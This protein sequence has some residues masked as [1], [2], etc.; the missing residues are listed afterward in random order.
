MT[1]IPG[2]NMRKNTIRETETIRQFVDTWNLNDRLCRATDEEIG[3]VERTLGITLPSVYTYLM[4]EFG[5]I[6]TPYILDAVVEQRIAFPDVQD[7]DLPLIALES[8]RACIRAGMPEG[9]FGFAW[10][11]MGNRFCFRCDECTAGRED[12]PVWYFDHDV[13]EM[14]EISVS[15]TEWLAFY[16][17]LGVPRGRR[18]GGYAHVAP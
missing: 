13:L 15:F 5:D 8:T 16:A 2:E 11:C 12:S 17:R 4:R 9:Y 14:R 1:D 10:D 6:Y 3:Q 18:S 7:F